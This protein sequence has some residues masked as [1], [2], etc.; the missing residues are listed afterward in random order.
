LALHIVVA[1]DG[2]DEEEKGPV[3][4]NADARNGTNFEGT[5]HARDDNS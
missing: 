5:F 4:E 3:E 1:K 2:R